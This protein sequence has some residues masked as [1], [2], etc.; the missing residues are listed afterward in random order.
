MFT[1][2]SHYLFYRL[3]YGFKIDGRSTRG[4]KMKKMR[5]VEVMTSS[6]IT[7]MDNSETVETTA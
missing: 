2:N 3:K 4:K 5:K 1:T 7:K 6:T